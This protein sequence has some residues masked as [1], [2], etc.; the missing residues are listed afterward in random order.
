MF[1][2]GQL[3]GLEE[4]REGALAKIFI[5]MQCQ[6]RRVLV[7]VLYQGKILEKKGISSVQRNIKLYYSCRVSSCGPSVEK[8]FLGSLKHCY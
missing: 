5:K 2:A 3:S 8:A 1:R 7:H 6:A 4:I